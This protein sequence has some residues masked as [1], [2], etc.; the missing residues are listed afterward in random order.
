MVREKRSRRE[1]EIDQNRDNRPRDLRRS[2]WELLLHLALKDP[3]AD[4]A[5]REGRKWEGERS[6]E[7][8]ADLAFRGRAMCGATSFKSTLPFG[9]PG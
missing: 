5:G 3:G 8:Q 6:C 9:P 4:W 2:L 7:G 1:P